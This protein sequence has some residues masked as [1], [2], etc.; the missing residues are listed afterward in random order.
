MKVNSDLLGGNPSVQEKEKPPKK[1]RGFLLFILT[2]VLAA[3]ILT[4]IYFFGLGRPM[5]SPVSESKADPT[6]TVQVYGEAAVPEFMEEDGEIPVLFADGETR[7]VKPRE[8]GTLPYETGMVRLYAD[9]TTSFAQGHTEEELSPLAGVEGYELLAIQ[10]GTDPEGEFVSYRGD[11]VLTNNPEA[12]E[13]YAYIPEGG[14]V[15]FVYTGTEGTYTYADADVFDLDVTDGGYY[16]R[17][18][19]KAIHETSGQAEEEGAIYVKT[20][21]EG[22]HTPENYEGEGMRLSFGG[23]G[24]PTGYF[25]EEI[26]ASGEVKTGMVSGLDGEGNLLFSEGTAFLPLFTEEELTGKTWYGD[27]AYSF[28]YE[29]RGVSETLYAVESEW[30]TAAEGLTSVDAGFWIGDVRPSFG[31]DGHD[32]AWGNG[33]EDTRYLTEDGSEA[34]P[35]TRYREI[36]NL[37]FGY[38]QERTFTL[39]PGY[40][41]PLSLFACADDDLWVFLTPEGGEASLVLD[42]GGMHGA[43]GAYVD[44]WDVLSPIPYGEEGETYT[45]TVLGLERDGV[46][47]LLYLETN[48]PDGELPEG[49]RRDVSVSAQESGSFVFDNGTRNLYWAEYPDGTGF[50]LVSGEPFPLEAGQEIV[51][52]GITGGTL[53]REGE[54]ETWHG[55]D[56][57]YE[58]GNAADLSGAE[59]VEFRR[60]PILRF[61][62][63]P[64]RSWRR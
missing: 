23:E 63:A 2:A 50:D 53:T 62:E 37:F 61:R 25:G 47:A 3:G 16:R 28:A 49:E 43:Q 44:L 60:R 58:K 6:F 56:G 18:N 33:S 35:A 22:I 21:E 26:N 8:D 40:V 11:S 38:R 42:L 9:D 24:I 46:D 54:G 55:A 1:K 59:A 30:G 32:I 19:E 64:V 5:G 51:I 27:G 13:G 17:V 14:I 31:T 36:H 34:L 4:C 15:R 29:K 10:V 20:M 48:L 41:G 57:S 12:G 39:T 45:L 7:Y 52:R